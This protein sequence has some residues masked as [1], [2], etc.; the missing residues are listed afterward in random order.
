LTLLLILGETNIGLWLHDRINEISAAA[1]YNVL[2][3]FDI[4]LVRYR[5]RLVGPH[6]M[7][8]AGDRPGA[9]FFATITAGVICAWPVSWKRRLI[10]L[11]SAFLGIAALSLLLLTVIALIN[12]QS[13]ALARWSR[14]YVWPCGM[15]VPAIAALWC[16]GSDQNITASPDPAAAVV[17]R[18]APD[19]PK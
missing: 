3:A 8:R 18:S 6:G 10:W 11:A 14:D 7:V 4:P 5:D 19:S 17:N 15:L 9:L 12:L 13:P 1:V 16:M 2:S